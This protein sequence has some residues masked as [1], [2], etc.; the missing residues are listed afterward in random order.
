MVLSSPVS[1]T[2]VL[3]VSFHP[4]SGIRDQR[5]TGI[6]FYSDLNPWPSANWK[7]SNPLGYPGLGII[8]FLSSYKPHLG[9]NLL[10][11]RQTGT[12]PPEPYIVALAADTSDNIKPKLYIIA[13]LF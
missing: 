11:W 9:V 2:N 12:L 7:T 8:E 13:F 10:T 5:I 3:P 6:G 1:G 4:R